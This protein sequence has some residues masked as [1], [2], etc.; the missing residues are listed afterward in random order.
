MPSRKNKEKKPT[1]SKKGNVELAIDFCRLRDA[2][3]TPLRIAVLKALWSEAHPLGAYKVRDLVS[4]KLKR[5]I[6]A[7]SIYRTLDFLCDLGVASRIES[8]NAYMACAHFEHDHACVFL[9]C[10]GCGDA[11]EIENTA[12]EQLIKSDANR[13]GFSLKHRVVELSGVCGACR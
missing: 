7:P 10:D 11:T 9:V 1:F 8:R 2:Q 4:S 3:M 5:D 6:A 12:L 13:V